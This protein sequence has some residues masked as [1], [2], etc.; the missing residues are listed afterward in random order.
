MKCGPA[1]SRAE[2]HR[3]GAK[4]SERG[5]HL[6]PHRRTGPGVIPKEIRRA[7]R[8]RG[9][10]PFPMRQ[11]GKKPEKSAMQTNEGK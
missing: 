5:R 7:L 11:K 6:Q 3:G 1:V 10:S 9:G 8:I 2:K 4:S